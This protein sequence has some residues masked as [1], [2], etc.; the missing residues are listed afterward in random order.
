MIRTET[1]ETVAAGQLRAFVERIE[2]VEEE[3]K[4]LN[5]DKSE[6]YKEARG[7]GFDVKSIRQCVAARK[8]DAAEFEERTAIFDLYWSALNGQP[9]RVHVHESNK[10]PA[11]ES[12]GTATGESPSGK[13]NAAR[14]ASVDAYVNDGGPAGQVGDEVVTAGET[15]PFE[16][17]AFL[18][19]DKPL[20]PHCRKPDDCAGYGKTHCHVCLKASGELEAA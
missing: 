11:Q 18:R 8:L 7:V 16:P 9:S 15:A 1:S 2:R 20:R 3:I 10:L 4:T 6:I 14:P 12:N 13:S 5:T 17:P 19:Q